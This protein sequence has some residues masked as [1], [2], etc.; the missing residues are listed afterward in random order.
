MSLRSPDNAPPH[1]C[2]HHVHEP[3]GGDSEVMLSALFTLS[4][5]V[6]VFITHLFYYFTIGFSDI[7]CI[8]AVLRVELLFKGVLKGRS[9]RLKC[10]LKGCECF[11]IRSNTLGI[12]HR[13]RSDASQGPVRVSTSWSSSTRTCDFCCE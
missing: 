7:C 5:K 2:C 8:V 11:N 13:D 6:I 10:F 4:N 1:H 3:A 9:D 12:P